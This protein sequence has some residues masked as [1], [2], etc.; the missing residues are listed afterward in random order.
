[1]QTGAG[2]TDGAIHTLSAVR[3]AL[4]E[5]VRGISGTAVRVED[6]ALPHRLAD[7][8]LPLSKLRTPEEELRKRLSQAALP[9]QV[10]EACLRG[11]TLC[12]RLSDGFLQGAAAEQGKRLPE[13]VLPGEI[14]I[15]ASGAAP[16]EDA[17]AY[18]LSLAVCAHRGGRPFREDRAHAALIRCLLLME[19]LGD[20]ATAAAAARAVLKA[21][22]KGLF[23]GEPVLFMAKSLSLAVQTKARTSKGE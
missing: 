20:G 13:P 15:P 14:A 6:I 8:A 3:E 11:K 18:A 4:A 2:A 21:F 16:D 19:A 5:L 22:D 17:C 12:F 1:M 7:A 23:G 10:S 9:P